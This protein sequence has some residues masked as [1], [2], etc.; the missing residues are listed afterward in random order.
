MRI[1]KNIIVVIVAYLFFAGM[2]F[3]QAI[4]FDNTRD[5]NIPDYA[6]L[7]IGPF[8]STVAF[9]QQ[10]GYRWTGSSGKGTDYLYNNRR[11]EIRK[12]GSDFPLISTLSFRNYVL[13]TR[14]MDL[15][16]S[17]WMSYEYYP[18]DTQEGGFYFDMPEEGV[19][20]TITLNYRITPVL[21]GTLYDRFKYRTDYFDTRGNADR[22]GGERYEYIDNTIGTYL[23]WNFARGKK[24]RF[25]VSRQDVIPFSDGFDDQ[26]RITYEQMLE[27]SQRVIGNISVG[28][29]Y[30]FNQTT[31]KVDY[32]P[33][34]SYQSFYLFARYNDG[35]GDDNGL[36][37]KMSDYTTA[38]IGIGYSAGVNGEIRAGDQI[39]NVDG[40]ISTNN[41]SDIYGADGNNFAQFIW[42]ASIKT[43]LME[44]VWHSLGYSSSINT[45]YR[46]AFE[47]VDSLEYRLEWH[48][49]A[50]TATL[51]SE[52]RTT[53][54]SGNIFSD[55]AD[56]ITRLDVT[57]PLTRYIEL[58]GVLRYQVRENQPNLLP[59][60]LYD[61]ET[62]SNY[63]TWMGRIG[64]SFAVTKTIKFYTYY[65]HVSRDSDNDDLVYTRDIFEAY[66]R[67]T[68]QF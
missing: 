21:T 7:R 38:S 48:G 64:S 16:I 41:I 2:L 1:Y 65:T 3:G 45:G 60:E 50:T 36:H 25:D 8:Y 40:V 17:F 43:L 57:Y 18:L 32:R 42:F 44:D 58:H 62:T 27:Y 6:T 15:D 22:Y 23:D 61:P 49:E 66:F 5:V 33:D 10:F 54:P 51:L 11:G 28:G 12:D 53:V 9:T 68:H 47:L 35:L 55:Y 26:E 20:G 46:T 37:I 34:N 52:Y 19:L 30:S 31:Y 59:N 56:W 63:D 13:I 4:T 29:N 24:F 14:K 67:Y 39:R